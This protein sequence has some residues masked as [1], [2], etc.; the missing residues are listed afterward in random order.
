MSGLLSS[1]VENSWWWI[2]CT[3]RTSSC[4]TTPFCVCRSLWYTTGMTVFTFLHIKNEKNQLF[5]SHLFIAVLTGFLP[6]TFAHFVHQHCIS[7]LSLT[8]LKYYRLQTFV[9]VDMVGIACTCLQTEGVFNTAR[10]THCHL[11]SVAAVFLWEILLIV[12]LLSWQRYRG[13]CATYPSGLQLKQM[14]VWLKLFYYFL[15]KHLRRSVQWPQLSDVNFVFWRIFF[16]HQNYTSQISK[17]LLGI[18]V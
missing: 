15:V 3:T 14:L 1:W 16:N 12:P 13:T 8:A 7:R 17:D 5:L 18:N 6:C 10:H 9:P 11:E 2:T 4:A